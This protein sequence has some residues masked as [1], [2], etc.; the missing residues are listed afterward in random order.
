MIH[1][2]ARAQLAYADSVPT[3]TYRDMTERL[4]L[5]DPAKISVPTLVARG[6]HDGIASMADLLGFYERLASAD[7][8]FAVVPGLAHVTPLGRYRHRMWR[9]LDAFFRLHAG[10]DG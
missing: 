10:A 5:V 4:P 9:L 6:E 7:K 2:C 8:Q 3:G 1:A